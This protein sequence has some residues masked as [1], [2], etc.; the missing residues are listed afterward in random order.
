MRPTTSFPE[1]ANNLGFI[2]EQ[3]ALWLERPIVQ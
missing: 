1:K 3:Q 2:N